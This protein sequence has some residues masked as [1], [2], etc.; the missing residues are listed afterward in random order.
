ME[1]GQR[2]YVVMSRAIGEHGESV[3]AGLGWVY[4]DNGGIFVEHRGTSYDQVKEEIELSIGS[5]IRYRPFLKSQ[6]K[7]Y[8]IVGVDKA[9]EPTC[10]LVAAI[11]T[12]EAW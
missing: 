6:E 2:L 8:K 1:M 9:L 12:S 4:T 5:M 10:A 11:Y 3:Y 7:H